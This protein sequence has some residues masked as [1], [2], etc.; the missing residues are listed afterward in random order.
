MLESLKQAILLVQWDSDPCVANRE[1]D[2]GAVIG[3]LDGR[4]FDGNFSLPG[5]LDRVA[6]QVNQ[7]L[8]QAHGVAAKVAGHVSS[9]AKSQ[10]QALLV[11]KKRQASQSIADHVRQVKR[12]GVENRLARLQL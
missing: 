11:S 10:F 8:S 3:N 2:T 9:D 6:Y 12:R 7:D 1:A 4:H 5:E